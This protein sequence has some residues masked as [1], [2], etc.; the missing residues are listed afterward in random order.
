MALV[1]DDANAD[2]LRRRG[3]E[4]LDITVIDADFGIGF[5]DDDGFELLARVRL[6]DDLVAK[7]EK[8]FDHDG[9]LRYAAVPPTVNA[10]TRNVGVPSP[11]GTP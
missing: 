4:C 7:R 5:F 6:G 10:G 1:I 11:T 3:R 9:F 2:A 8:F